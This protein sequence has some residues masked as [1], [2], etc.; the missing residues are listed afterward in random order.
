MLPTLNEFIAAAEQGRIDMH[1]IVCNEHTMLG[2]KY[3]T[4]TVYSEDWDNVSLHARGIVFDYE[5]SKVLARPFDKFF[6]LG[7]MIDENGNL[8]PIAGYVKQHLGFDNLSGDYKHQKFRVMDKLDGSLGIM[9]WTGV[10]WLVKTAGSFT[11]DQATWANNWAAT[12]IDTSKLDTTK[13]YLFEII[14]NEDKHP[15]SYDFEGMVLL[16][17][18][19]TQTGKEEP[20][21]EILRVAKE[22]N[23]K[24]AEVLEFNDFDEVIKYAK[25][26]PKTKEG[27]VITFENGF[28]LKVKGDEFLQLQKIFH[29]LNK[30]VIYDNLKWGTIGESTELEFA[31]TDGFIIDIPEELED[32]KSYADNLRKDFLFYMDLTASYG[33]YLHNKYSDNRRAAYEYIS[34]A[35]QGEFKKLVAAIMM[36][37]TSGEINTKIRG[38][39]HKALK[40]QKVA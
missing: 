29:Y 5:T 2:F 1:T 7:E 3:T 35:L 26:L 23:V 40:P 36:Y 34:T 9:F 31:Y 12:N 25:N 4:N 10:K 39:I 22:L 28:K 27:V 6:N 32:L 16:G 14:Y 37:Y 21:S 38:A 17:I 8:K 19:D 20:L 18:V 11:S 33:K 15:I 24:H 13:T 30:E